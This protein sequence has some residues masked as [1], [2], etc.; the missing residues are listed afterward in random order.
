M[1]N[2][3]TRA[4]SSRL[5]ELRQERGLIRSEVLEALG[6][7]GIEM[8]LTT[9]RR[10]EDARQSVRLDE[11]VA[12]ADIYGTTLSELVAGSGD[13][14]EAQ[15]GQIQRQ[16]RKVGSRL[17]GVAEEL[18]DFDRELSKL[19][20]TEAVE[21]VRDWLSPELGKLR[22]AAESLS[23]GPGW[24]EHLEQLRQEAH[25]DVHPGQYDQLEEI[26][27]APELPPEELERQAAAAEAYLRQLRN[28]SR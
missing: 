6:A 22:S 19:E 27:E 23:H 8:G 13:S 4:S 21:E 17:V 18:G 26:P 7:R 11:A 15:A 10:I 20:Q 3:V 16:I 28:G 12:L 14:A 24:F 5:L 25:S 1:V 2:P 9:L